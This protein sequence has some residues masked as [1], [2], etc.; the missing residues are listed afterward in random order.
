[1]YLDVRTHRRLCTFPS[2]S[3]LASR[4]G[5]PVWHQ[6]RGPPRDHDHR[7]LRQQLYVCSPGDV[8]G[9]IYRAVVPTHSL[10]IHP[11]HHPAVVLADNHFT[12]VDA[13]NPFAPSS[14]FLAAIATVAN[15]SSAVIADTDAGGLLLDN[16]MAAIYLER[17]DQAE[18][19]RETG[20]IFG[21]G[22]FG[23][24]V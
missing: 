5:L 12:V 13:G 2:P 18:V 20:V 6:H 22:I 21:R 16:G 17:V 11:T 10:F 7:P 23:V 8:S 3:S 19:C 14:P 1:M 15:A 24:V 9:L 4:V